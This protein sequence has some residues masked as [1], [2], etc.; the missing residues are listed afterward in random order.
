MSELLPFIATEYTMPHDPSPTPSP[1]SNI[2]QDVSNFR[3]IHVV[4]MQPEEI[5]LEDR[6]IPALGPTDILVKVMPTGM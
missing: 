3:N 1:P 6:P 5:I 4:L 2:S